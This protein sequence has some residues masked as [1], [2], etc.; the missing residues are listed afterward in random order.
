[1][2]TL[3]TRLNED[4]PTLR[5]VELEAMDGCRYYEISQALRRNKAVQSLCIND[6]LFDIEGFQSPTWRKLRRLL[7]SVR[8]MDNLEDLGLFGKMSLDNIHDVQVIAK[9]I[10]GHPVLRE[11]KLLDFIIYAA[12]HVDSAPLLESLLTA[13]SSIDNL[14]AFQLRCMA[15]Y[16]HWSRSYMTSQVL[17]PVCQ[18][19]RLQRLALSNVGLRDEHFLTIAQEVGDN[20][21][22]AL[23]ELI[24]N[25][26]QNSDIGVEAIAQLLGRNKT[27]SRLEAHS[28]NRLGESTCEL[29]LHRL[30]K[31]HVIKYLRVNVPYTYRTEIDFYLLLNRAGR[32]SLLDPD[33]VPAQAVNVLAAANGNVSVLM[34]LL[35][36]SPSLCQHPYAKEECKIENSSL[37]DEAERSA[38]A[39]SALTYSMGSVEVSAQSDDMEDPPSPETLGI[40][41]NLADDSVLIWRRFWYRTR[42]TELDRNH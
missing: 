10:S 35:R 30:D 41:K 26:N 31:N 20:T 29:T 37:P 19:T 27:I 34:H 24:L 3:L 7:Q 2:A 8:Y 36:E 18:S 25:D 13:A 15:S 38:N 5:K 1:M 16:K 23:E 11:V 6:G 17:I 9:A 4:D 40:L 39:T 21:N 33:V 28:V 14:E 42:S 22:T 12:D 32:K